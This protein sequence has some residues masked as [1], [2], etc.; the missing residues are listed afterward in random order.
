MPGAVDRPQ[1]GEDPDQPPGDVQLDEGV[2]QGEGHD[3]HQDDEQ[4]VVMALRAL[5]PSPR[6]YLGSWYRRWLGLL[7]AGQVVEQPAQVRLGLGSH[8]LID[9]LVELG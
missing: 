6:S 2:R 4:E 9:A 7:E 3:D 8:G 5:V 1:E